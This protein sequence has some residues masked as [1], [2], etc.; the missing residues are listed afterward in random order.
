MRPRL[1][2]VKQVGGALSESASIRANLST[3]RPLASGHWAGGI[4]LKIENRAASGMFQQYF[5][6]RFKTRA[7]RSQRNDRASPVNAKEPIKTRSACLAGAV[8]FNFRLLG[9]LIL[10]TASLTSRSK[11]GAKVDQERVVPNEGRLAPRNARGDHFRAV[12]MALPRP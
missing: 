7:E 10:S 6:T 3:I 8:V 5:R 2:L 1:L 11:L 12:T 9:R 4:T